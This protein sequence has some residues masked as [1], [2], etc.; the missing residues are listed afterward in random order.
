MPALG[1]A[2]QNGVSEA[3][4]RN[5]QH[6]MIWMGVGILIGYLII[7]FIMKS[8]HGMRGNKIAELKKMASEIDTLKKTVTA[9]SIEIFSLKAVVAANDATISSERL[10]GTNA[11]L[12]VV[13]LTP[14]EKE[15]NDL[16]P[17]VGTLRDE[18]RAK[19]QEIAS[20]KADITKIQSDLEI[21]YQRF[22]VVNQ[23]AAESK[24][25]EKNLNRVIRE[26]EAALKKIR[27]QL[28][29]R[30]EVLQEKHED[31][32][33]LVQQQQKMEIGAVRIDVNSEVE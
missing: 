9:N 10:S 33:E 22:E 13:R 20:L 6:D 21:A 31:M 14:F 3:P 5:F 27:A 15:A 16:R 24:T 29:G 28:E 23:R 19:N 30:R 32:K 4:P 17:Q 8:L 12:Q 26:Q 2:V 25:A 7:S 18:I 1:I 11:K